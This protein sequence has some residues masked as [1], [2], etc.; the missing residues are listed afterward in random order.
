MTRFSGKVGYANPVRMNGVVENVITERI[1]MG[2]ELRN[3]RYFA[4][5]DSILGQVSLPTRLSV[6]ADAY[7]LENFKNIRYVEWAG[8]HWNV[9]SVQADRPR[10]ILT[11]GE[12]YNGPF[13]EENP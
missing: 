7:A 1:L 2:D 11:L 13:P 8:S 10:L 12:K 5:Q 6:V 9:D 3:T 4:N